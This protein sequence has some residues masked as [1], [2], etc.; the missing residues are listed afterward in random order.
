LADD[1][2]RRLA[3][4]LAAPPGLRVQ[5]CTTNVPMPEAP[6][7]PRMAARVCRCA[8]GPSKRPVWYVGAR[9]GQHPRLIADNHVRARTTMSQRGALCE[10]LLQFLD[11]RGRLEALRARGGAAWRTSDAPLAKHLG[12]E[13]KQVRR[14][15]LCLAG[16]AGRYGGWG[17][18]RRVWGLPSR[19]ANRRSLLRTRMPAP[20]SAAPLEPGGAPHARAGGCT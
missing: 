11:R 10:T 13:D 20:R 1:V 4:E 2:A 14:A 6:S 9:L 5:V 7:P 19:H 17:W 16:N 12:R 8:C 15:P 18:R 3:E